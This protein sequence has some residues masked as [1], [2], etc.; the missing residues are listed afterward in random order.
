M[1]YEEKRVRVKKYGVLPRNSPLL[2]EIPST[3]RKP[4]KLHKLAAA[5]FHKM[6]EEAKAE[7]GIELKAASAWRRHRW[8]SWEHFE[9]TMI[10]KYGSV[11][12]GRKWVAYNSP[13][14]TGLAVDFGVGGLEPSRRTA[15]KQRETPLHKW[16]VENA[17]R[18]G[19]H[20]YKRE[21]W[22]WEFT[23]SKKAWETGDPADLGDDDLEGVLSFSD[24]EDDFYGIIEDEDSLNEVSAFVGEGDGEEPTEDEAGDDAPAQ[25]AAQASAAATPPDTPNVG[26]IGGEI[27]TVGDFRLRWSVHWKI[28]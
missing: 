17:Y 21:P 6:A 1:S 14:E 24:E 25:V 18:F 15:K 22:H 20:P 4:M 26:Q 10:R 28:G 27:E 13:H 12:E 11:R 2:A 3:R 9:E 23:I 16:L 8:R 19:F 5:A 7:L